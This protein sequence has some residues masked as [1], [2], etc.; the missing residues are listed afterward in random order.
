MKHHLESPL[1][2]SNMFAFI[3]K[4]CLLLAFFGIAN[5]DQCDQDATLFGEGREICQQTGL[6]MK[7]VRNNDL[8]SVKCYNKDFTE[9]R[10]EWETRGT[11]SGTGPIDSWAQ[12][13]QGCY[14]LDWGAVADPWSLTVICR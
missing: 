14:R 7:I 3:S 10:R 11:S 6:C 13:S 12:Q 5:A 9:P 8:L 4:I 2:L 1:Y